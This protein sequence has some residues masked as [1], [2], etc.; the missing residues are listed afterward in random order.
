MTG[1]TCEQESKLVYKFVFSSNFT[2]D[3]LKKCLNVLTKFFQLKQPFSFYVDASKANVAPVNATV[4]LVKWM[5]S[6]KPMIIEHRK[7]IGGCVVI[8][9]KT[10]TKI[11]ET[12]FK[13]QKPICPVKITNNL[14]SA[15]LFIKDITEKYVLNNGITLVDEKNSDSVTHLQ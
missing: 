1:F 5:R 10:V 14:D 13:I 7:F 9:N 6:I 8:K 15:K 3:D 4:N 11:L 2:D 12:V